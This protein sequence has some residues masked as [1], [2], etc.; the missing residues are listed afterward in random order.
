MSKRGSL[1]FC[2]GNRSIGSNNE[3]VLSAADVFW[4]SRF[5]IQHIENICV[6]RN[7]GQHMNVVTRYGSFSGFEL[8]IE[9]GLV[10]LPRFNDLFA[11]G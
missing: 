11:I 6:F 4:Q 5:A 7:I 8:H 2:H 9:D 1:S 10:Q 3:N